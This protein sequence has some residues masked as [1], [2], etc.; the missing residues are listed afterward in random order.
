[1][2]AKA[3][4]YLNR[5]LDSLSPE[6][7]SAI[8]SVSAD[9]YCAD[10]YNANVCAELVRI[11]QKTASCS[12]ELWYR[13]HGEPM[14]E[15][16]HLQVVTNWDDEPVCVIQMTDVS[17]CRY[18]EV[19]A[20]FAYAEGEGDRTLNWWRDAH[21]AFFKAECDELNIDW[22]EQR[23]LVLERFKVVYPFE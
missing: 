17:T 6:Q 10:E 15:V 12:M 18:D 14:P 19:T 7:K 1:M 16:G 2:D 8:P 5:Y 22:H 13:E 20:E 9:Y 11:G 3:K 4:N 23:L 21:A